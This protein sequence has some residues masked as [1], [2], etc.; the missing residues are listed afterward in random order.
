MIAGVP[1]PRRPVGWVDLSTE[2]ALYM[3]STAHPVD[4]NQYRGI[5][6][7]EDP[8]PF[9]VIVEYCC[10]MPNRVVRI[11][12]SGEGVEARAYRPVLQSV[13][14]ETPCPP[15]SQVL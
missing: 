13:I 6:V 2:L 10:D 7:L 4:A 15:T 14:L 1:H 12:F 5:R 9:P 8:I 3:L 11:G